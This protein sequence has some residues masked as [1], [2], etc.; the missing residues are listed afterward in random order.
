MFIVAV[1]LLSEV[2]HS[3]T[4][5]LNQLQYQRSGIGVKYFGV[6]MAMIQLLTMLSAKSYVITKSIGQG[7]TVSIMAGGIC[8]GT[9]LLVFTS[10]PMASIML[11]AMVGL[12]NAMILPI[13]SDIQNKSISTSDRATI[14]SAYAMTIDI[15]SAFINMAIGKTANQSIQLS[16]VVCS[17]LAAAAL[18]M[19]WYFFRRTN[20]KSLKDGNFI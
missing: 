7:K 19:S 3:V 12:C 13:S 18:L 11:I 15:V 1:A 10:N 17:V 9:L 8:I 2:S 16:F 6:I 20:A 14:L 4:V 5:F